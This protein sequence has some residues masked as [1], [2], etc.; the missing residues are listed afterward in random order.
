MHI[1]IKSQWCTLWWTHIKLLCYCMSIMLQLKKKYPQ[2]ICSK[3]L[4]QKALSDTIYSLATGCLLC[5]TFCARLW[6]VHDKPN[7]SGSCPFLTL[8]LM[9]LCSSSTLNV[10]TPTKR[11]AS[12]V[13]RPCWHCLN[14]WIQKLLS[15]V[16]TECLHFNRKNFFFLVLSSLE[17][18]LTQ[19]DS[20]MPQNSSARNWTR[21]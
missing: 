8:S 11:F 17:W 9:K 19:E 1:N 20:P 18:N 10:Y 13:Y 6:G 16:G 2:Q 7:K 3:N 5:T 21:A 4:E 15:D 12:F 14:L